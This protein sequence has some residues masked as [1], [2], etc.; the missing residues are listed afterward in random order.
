MDKRIRNRSHKRWKNNVL[1]SLVRMMTLGVMTIS[2]TLKAP[3]RQVSHSVGRNRRY[4]I[5]VS[6][7]GV[8]RQKKPSMTI[9][10]IYCQLFFQEKG[11]DPYL[12]VAVEFSGFHPPQFF[13]P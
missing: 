4:E 3:A 1:E 2:R 11:M 13:P 12:P 10:F 9:F 7:R 8:H 5:E 6:Y